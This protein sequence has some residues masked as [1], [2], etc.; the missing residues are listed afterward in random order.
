MGAIISQHMLGS[1]LCSWSIRDTR[2]TNLKM[3]IR[4]MLL[5]ISRSTLE[6]FWVVWGRKLWIPLPL[7]IRNSTWRLRYPS[8]KLKRGI[9]VDYIDL[10]I[11][12]SQP[13]TKTARWSA[14]SMAVTAVTSIFKTQGTGTADS[15]RLLGYFY[16]NADQPWR[17]NSG[18]RF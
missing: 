5:L 4:S 14:N 2:C 17:K 3:A 7:P 13:F 10:P 15:W 9:F 18:I 1:I 12:S 6:S 11:S 16:D 8:G